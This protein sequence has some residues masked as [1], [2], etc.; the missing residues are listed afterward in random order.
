[1]LMAAVGDVAAA[2]PQ[3]APGV[4][5]T[6]LPDLPGIEMFRCDRWSATMSVVSCAKRWSAQR[7][8][9]VE[10]R[11]ACY[12]CALGA[13]HAGEEPARRSRIFSWPICPRCRR[14]TMRRMIGNR[15]CINCFNREREWR[16][17]RNSKGR[18]PRKL[19]LVPARLGLVLDPGGAGE[20]YL[21]IAEPAVRDVIELGIAAL[22]VVD[23]AVAFCRPRG[24]V[25][26]MTITELA[27]MFAAK[28]TRLSS[29]DLRAADIVRRHKDVRGWNARA[30][31]RRRAAA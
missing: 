22:R 8:A 23:D 28:P 2:A 15:R 9:A 11:S 10:A 6:I 25:P 27:G 19:R 4:I 18:P 20:R 16:I 26:A 30:P 14:L 7:D 1:M 24:D 31:M 21:E 3:R 12:G 5:Y 13:C 17:G 29:A